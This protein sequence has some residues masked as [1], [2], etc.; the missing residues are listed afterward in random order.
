MPADYRFPKEQTAWDSLTGNALFQFVVDAF[1]GCFFDLTEFAAMKGRSFLVTQKTAPRIYR[2]YRIASE[3]L[4]VEPDIPVYI[5]QDYS[6]QIETVGTDGD[7]AIILSSACAEASSQAQ[8]L[9]LFGQ[10]LSHIRYGH[11]RMLNI[12]KLIDPLLRLLPFVGNAAAELFKTLLLDWRQN[13]LYTADRGAAI[14][15]QNADAV[16]YNLSAAMGMKLDG[17]GL[18]A[19]LGRSGSGT[20]QKDEMS[21]MGKAVLQIMMDQIAV[22]FGM[23]RMRELKSWCAEESCRDLFPAVYYGTESEFGLDQIQDAPSLYRQALVMEPHNQSRAL[24]ML[25]AAANRGLPQAQARLGQYYLMGRSGLPKDFHTGL[26]LLRC[27][28]LAG[29]ADAWFGL[30]VCFRSG[31]GSLLPRD[32]QRAVWM[33][34]LAEAAGH[35]HAKSRLAGQRPDVLQEKIVKEALAWFLSSYRN[36]PCQINTSDPPAGLDINEELHRFLWIPSGERVLALECSRAPDGRLRGAIALT[37]V[38]IYQYENL[39][40]PFHMTWKSLYPYPM[41]GRKQGNSVT[42]R[43]GE[44]DFCRFSMDSGQREIGALILRIRRLIVKN[45]K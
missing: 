18:S 13:A 31:C 4:D 25:H 34:R 2:L 5:Q 42:L 16:L 23:W 19:A 21:A 44:N 7:C 36:G 1:Q 40:I 37:P 3:R 43:I 45:G 9:A 14:A 35:P 29:S 17:A 26:T 10:E 33:F 20:Y 8:L 32:E 41:D 28:A 38:G 15:A 12:H 6:L 39:G 27:A 24:A 22:P 30:G 11:V